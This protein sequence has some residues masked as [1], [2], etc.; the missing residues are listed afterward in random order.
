M[1]TKNGNTIN[2]NGR[3]DSNN[4]AEFEK[5]LLAATA[6]IYGDIILDATELEYISSAGLRVLLKLKKGTKGKVGII[7]QCIT[8]K[9]FGGILYD[10]IRNFTFD[11][12][13][14]SCS[15]NDHTN[16]ADAFGTSVVGRMDCT[17]QRYTIYRL[18]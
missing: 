11:R 15:L 4:A 17:R 6:E 7:Y 3:I 9:H 18:A 10:S 5:Q 12:F 13:C 16:T 1:I 14:Y 8:K 2:I